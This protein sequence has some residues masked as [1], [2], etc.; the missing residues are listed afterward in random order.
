ML[1]NIKQ[2]FQ[3][4][5]FHVFALPCLTSCTCIAVKNI[6]QCSCKTFY[7]YK[8]IYLSS[9]RVY[10]ITETTAL[11][12]SFF[13]GY[14]SGIKVKKIF[15][16]WCI[17]MLIYIWTNPLSLSWPKSFFFTKKSQYIVHQLQPLH[18]DSNA[19]HQRA[20]LQFNIIWKCVIT[21]HFFLCVI[22]Q[23]SRNDIS[24]WTF[25]LTLT[26]VC[27]TLPIKWPVKIARGGVLCI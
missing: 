14:V 23:V 5:W 18:P 19:F 1:A 16:I 12:G 25:T 27:Q 20:T 4:I 6:S 22:S 8:N 9:S 21:V 13:N 11:H 3:E 7:F 26:V 10:Q 2:C 15:I 24:P 17:N